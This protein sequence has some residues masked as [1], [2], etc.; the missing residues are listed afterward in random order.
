MANEKKIGNICKISYGTWKINGMGQWSIDG[1]TSDQLE[2]TEFGDTWKTFKMGLKDGGQVSFSGLF[3]DPDT[4]GQEALRTANLNNTEITN[5]RFYTDN[6]SYFIPTTT[7]PASYI[8][9]TGWTVSADKSGM[10]Q[11]N[12]TGK[13][14]GYLEHL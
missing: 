14:S 7:N 11:A 3:Y 4:N 6:T 12:F 5:L 13:V 1:I 8:N 2:Q 9:I 10:L